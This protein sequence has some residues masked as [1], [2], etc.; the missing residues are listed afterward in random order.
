MISDDV[1]EID[2]SISSTVGHIWSHSKIVSL[3][4][5]FG[6]VYL[7]ATAISGSSFSRLLVVFGVIALVGWFSLAVFIQKFFRDN[8]TTDNTIP[9]DAIELIAYKEGGLVRQPNLTVIYT[10][11]GEQM[12][13]N[14][15]LLPGWLGENAPLKRI[16]P[17]L[18]EEGLDTKPVE[19]VNA[20]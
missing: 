4:L 11:D 9:R 19:E 8:V 16:L 17:L 2:T 5:I 6:L 18:E 15:F 3:A 7:V 12:G 1:I 10:E 14:I 20:S 13:R